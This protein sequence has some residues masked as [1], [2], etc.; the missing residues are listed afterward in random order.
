MLTERPPCPVPSPCKCPVVLLGPRQ[1]ANG[2]ATQRSG[3]RRHD[4]T[5][6][7]TRGKTEKIKTVKNRHFSI[8]AAALVWGLF[9]FQ[10]ANAA[11]ITTDLTT[12][13]VVPGIN[14]FITDGAAMVGMSVTVN[15]L[16]GA[17]E[18]VAWA[19]TD[20]QSGA[21]TGAFGTGWSISSS[22]DTFNSN[23]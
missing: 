20:P 11:I 1:G 16:G 12:V 14:R 21:A 19:A 13:D 22:G 7:E 18:T 5:F 3:S 23:A 2:G 15:F 10:S 8:A 6:H 4:S 9:S 17:S